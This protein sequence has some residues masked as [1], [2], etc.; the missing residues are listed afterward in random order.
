VRLSGQHGGSFSVPIMPRDVH[1]S[2]AR[3]LMVHAPGAESARA[4]AMLLWTER[5]RTEIGPERDITP[6]APRRGRFERAWSHAEAHR[7]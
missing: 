4:L 2:A 7:V 1:Q 6:G 5:V 3:L